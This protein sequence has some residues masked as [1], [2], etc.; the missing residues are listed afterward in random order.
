MENLEELYF[1]EGLTKI[2]AFG[3]SL[4]NLD[5]LKTV[6]IPSSVTK[7][8]GLINETEKEFAEVNI[9]K[10]CDNLTIICEEGSSGHEYAQK[11]GIK[12]LIM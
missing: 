4:H 1:S 3:D 2:R 5:N 10:D 9:F 12:T 7:I 11:Y 6:A 8:D